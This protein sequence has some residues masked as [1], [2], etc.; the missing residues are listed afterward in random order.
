MWFKIQLSIH[1][2][3]KYD[4]EFHLLNISVYQKKFEENTQRALNTIRSKLQ[5]LL[6]T[7]PFSNKIQSKVAIFRYEKTSKFKSTNLKDVS[8]IK[9]FSIYFLFF[10]V[11]V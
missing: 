3:Q 8:L 4:E 10:Y 11:K 5:A 7:K 1:T 2:I 9:E 6:D